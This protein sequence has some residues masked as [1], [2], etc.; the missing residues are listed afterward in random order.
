[1]K[2]RRGRIARALAVLL[3]TL[4]AACVLTHPGRT[5]LKSAGLMIEV[6]P[7]SPA[8]PLRWFT[9]EPV[10]EKVRYPSGGS[11]RVAE[12]YRPAGG[13]RHGAMLLYIGVGPYWNDPSLVRLANGLARSGVVVMVPESKVLGEYRIPEDASRDVTAAFRYLRSR[14]YVNPARVSMLGISVGGSL[15]AVAAEGSEISKQVRLLVLFGSYYDARDV[16]SAA[17]LERIPVNGRWE[18]WVPQ[19]VTVDVLENTLLPLVP[20]GDRKLLGPL[21]E[22][23]TTSI[24]RGLSPEGQRVARLLANHDPRRETE[25]LGQ[26]PPNVR[27]YL[28]RVSPST[29]IVRLRT[30]LFVM[31][32][33][34]DDI[35]PYTESL[36]LYGAA[37]QAS[38]KHLRLFD[39][40]RHVEPSGGNL[41]VLARELPGLYTEAYQV[42][43]RLT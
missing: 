16:L 8:Y 38:P 42:L 27:T 21:F 22:R 10:R 17:T 7:S 29:H 30:E 37:K 1:M 13:G 43:V 33:R 12:V 28:A 23:R 18:R 3:I 36:K 24:P 35:I 34:H 41:L 9:P 40:F 15:C 14:P 31:H 32:D 26:L 2:R 25:L 5:A 39:I 20:H 19:P 11:E 6:F 4:I